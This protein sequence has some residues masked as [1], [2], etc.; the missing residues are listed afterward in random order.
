VSALK[1]LTLQAFDANPPRRVAATTRGMTAL[2]SLPMPRPTSQTLTYGYDHLSRLT[3]AS[4]GPSGSTTYSYDPTG[5]RLT[6]VRNSTSISYAYDRADRISSAGAAS[7]TVNANGNL[8]ARGSDS[9]SYDQAN[10]L[11]STTVGSTTASYVYDGAGKRASKTVSSTTASY[12]YDVNRGLP[13][14]LED[15]TR[16]YVWGLG[17]AYMVESGAALVYHTDGLG[18]VR[19]VTNSSVGVVQTYD[20]DEFGVPIMAQGGSAQPFG[21][22]GEQRDGENNLVYLRARFYDPQLG[23]FIQRDLRFGQVSVP[24]SLNR[25]VYSLSNP[26][27]RVDPSGYKSSALSLMASCPIIIPERRLRATCD[28][29]SAGVGVVAGAISVIINTSNQ[30]EESEDL[31]SL[32]RSVGPEEL[33]DIIRFGDYGLSPNESGKYFALTE[34]G[35]REFAH[36]P[37]NESIEMTLTRIDVPRS[38]VE[39][40]YVFNDPR[41]GGLS[42]HFTDEQLYELYDLARATGGVKIIGPP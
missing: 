38:Y 7:Y 13:V 42:V 10:R 9:F 30:E 17:L 12:V 25:Y 19:A 2:A 24:S 26:V 35:A 20:F 22:T 32:W 8:T 39:S 21:F 23:R 31:I 34:E 1:L 41:G 40:G 18:S 4:G 3:S 28:V 37:F 5:N 6:R 29:A 16:R 14:L 27:N 33:S 11:T 15:D 36:T